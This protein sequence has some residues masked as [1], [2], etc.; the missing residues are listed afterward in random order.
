MWSYVL[1]LA[2]HTVLLVALA[3]WHLRGY[4]KAARASRRRVERMITAD[5]SEGYRRE[6]E[7]LRRRNEILMRGLFPRGEVFPGNFVDEDPEL[8]ALC[9]LIEL[10][11]GQPLPVEIRRGVGPA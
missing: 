8:Q 4:R 3:W 10:V 5:T 11:R 9:E 2:V 1:I 7:Y 6:N